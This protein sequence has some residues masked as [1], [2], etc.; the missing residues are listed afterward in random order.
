MVHLLDLNIGHIVDKGHGLIVL[1][2][3]DAQHHAAVYRF[4]Q[5]LGTGGDYIAE[6]ALLRRQP[7]NEGNTGGLAVLEYQA[8]Q[9]FV[10]GVVYLRVRAP[11]NTSRRPASDFGAAN[12]VPTMPDS[13]TQPSSSM[14]TWE[15]TSFTTLI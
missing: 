5:L 3:G 12:T 4:G 1:R 9:L 13:A 14:A 6:D 15:Q 11:G 10:L 8:D 7:G 2:A